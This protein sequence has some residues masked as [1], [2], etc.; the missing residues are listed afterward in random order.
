V[1]EV[2]LARRGDVAELLA[3][4]DYDVDT[5]TLAGAPATIASS[6]YALVACVESVGWDHLADLVA[7]TQADFTRLV[8]EAPSARNWDL[9]LVVLVDQV[10]PDSERRTVME[11]IES[12]TRY[13]RKFVHA[14]VTTADLDRA[15]RPLLPLRPAADFAIADPL[16]ELR[17]EL[18]AGGVDGTVV[19]EALRAFDAEN[20]VRVS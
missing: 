4:V 12:D 1:N 5:Y 16:D 10:P 18:L 11:S 15:L 2:R 7:D 14:G 3:S 6:P 17:D 13:A 9:Y 8:E 19:E 20:E